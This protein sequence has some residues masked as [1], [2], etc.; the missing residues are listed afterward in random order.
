VMKMASDDIRND[1]IQPISKS[2]P[3]LYLKQNKIFPIRPSFKVMF[4]FFYFS[5][6][7]NNLRVICYFE[8]M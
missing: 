7:K 4:A 2:I 8:I 5:V 1:I 6:K 3:R